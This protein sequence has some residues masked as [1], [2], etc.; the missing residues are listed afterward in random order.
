MFYFL[1][2]SFNFLSSKEFHAITNV[3][4]S[5]LES[6][7]DLPFI[8]TNFLKLILFRIPNYFGLMIICNLLFMFFAKVEYYKNAAPD[9]K[10][11]LVCV[12]QN[13]CFI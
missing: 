4:K 12:L 10:K 7:V 2:E 9:L 5:F 11:V 13:Y 3:N 6:I 1:A 8:E